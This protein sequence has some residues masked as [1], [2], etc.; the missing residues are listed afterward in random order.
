MNNSN[1]DQAIKNLETI[2]Q[3]LQKSSLDPKNYNTDFS[4][5][6]EQISWA[7]FKDAQ[8]LRAR[9]ELFGSL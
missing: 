9:K 3:V 2:S 5:Y 4:Y 6:L 1:I 7:L 8:E